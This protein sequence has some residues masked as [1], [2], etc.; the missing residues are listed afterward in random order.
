MK[1]KIRRAILMALADSSTVVHIDQL[2][3]H[4][5][6]LALNVEIEAIRDQAKLL[7]KHGYLV[8]PSL[9]FGLIALSTKEFTSIRQTSLPSLDEFLWGSMVAPSV[10]IR[11]RP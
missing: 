4:P 3:N 10:I 2:P 7:I 5:Q 9:D 8:Q 6:L 11:N 1:Y